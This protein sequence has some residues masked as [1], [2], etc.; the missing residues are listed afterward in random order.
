MTTDDEA[1]G[2]AVSEK[3]WGVDGGLG[4]CGWNGGVRERNLW[5]REGAEGETRALEPFC[6]EDFGRSLALAGA[7]SVFCAKDCA[8]SWQPPGENHRVAV[9]PAADP[10]LLLDRSL[11]PGPASK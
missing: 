8:W 2:A 3:P 4:F 9:G 10:L 11:P 6:P 1:L 7:W 5:E